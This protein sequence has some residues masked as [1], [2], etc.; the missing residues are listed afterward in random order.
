MRPDGTPA[1]SQVLIHPDRPG[2]HEAIT[3]DD[4]RKD[5]P[6]LPGLSE[7]TFS[8]H[9]GQ[10]LRARANVIAADALGTD[11][12]VPHGGILILDALD[13]L[14]EPLNT[15]VMSR[16]TGINQNH[17]DW[18]YALYDVEGNTVRF[19]PARDCME[20]HSRAEATDSLLYKPE[21]AQPVNLGPGSR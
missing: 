11:Q 12:K 15:F 1:G 19:G 7:E 14:G 2:L 20:C 18:L 13:G 16:W 21:D 8:G 10:I 17:G 4:D 5:W 3:K 6:S 9:H